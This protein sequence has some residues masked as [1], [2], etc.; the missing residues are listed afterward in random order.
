MKNYVVNISGGRS[1]GYMVPLFEQKRIV[2]DINVEYI[3]CDTGAEHPATYEFL[4]RIVEHWG[5]DLTC[6]RTVV[7][8]IKGVGSRYRV[9]PLSECKQDLEPFFD[10]IKVYGTPAPDIGR[11]TDE[12]KAIPCDKY[13]NEKY[14]R[15]SYTKWL[16][17]R[18]DE[19]NRIRL[20]DK[21]IDLFGEGKKVRPELLPLRYL[22]EIDDSDK[23]D[24]LE[25]W[26]AQPFDLEITEELGNCVFCP[27]KGVN[28]IALAA[29]KEPEM[30]Q[31][32]IDILES[33]KTRSHPSKIKAGLSNGQVFR[34]RMDLHSVIKA[35]EGIE[36][37]DLE[38]MIQKG[39]K[40]DTGSC[41]ESCEA[42]TVDLFSG[43]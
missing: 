28:K 23:Q 40:F 26:K 24:I 7:S 38:N 17:I 19:P 6:L 25:F 41:S 2:E 43:D 34:G 20:V 31:S 12:M 11:C 15:G 21:Q 33:T 18:A 9:V 4:R 16:G 1:S 39:R 13:C 37:S 8:P 36:T 42:M 32:F 29:R 5:I 10:Y 3:F 22:G 35:H 27:K 30:A 14:G